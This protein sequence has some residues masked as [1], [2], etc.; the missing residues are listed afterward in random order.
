MTTM[1]EKSLTDLRQEITE[2][3]PDN[4]DINKLGLIITISKDSLKETEKYQT[5]LMKQLQE[6]EVSLADI[7]RI[8]RVNIEQKAQL[9]Q[10]QQLSGRCL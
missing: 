9:E 6:F 2:L 1:L 5:L 8:L 4:C 3:R 7:N 10:Q